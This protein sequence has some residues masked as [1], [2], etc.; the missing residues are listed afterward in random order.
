MPDV[1][2][3]EHRLK[4]GK[5]R[6][7]MS[8]IRENEDLVSVG[9]YVAGSSARIDDALAHREAVEGFLQQPADDLVD[10]ESSVQALEDL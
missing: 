10:Y 7:W 8:L 4:A 5:V 3:R 6:D 1:T 9:A 2:T